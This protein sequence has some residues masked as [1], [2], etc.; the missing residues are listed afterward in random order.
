LASFVIIVK[1]LIFTF[2]L[3]GAGERHG[4]S[5]EVGIRLGQVSE[6]SLLISVLA[7]ESGF[8]GEITSNLIQMTTLL[9]FIVSSYLIVKY[10]PTPIAV[11][12][13]LRRD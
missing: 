6:F 9:T 13:N 10:Y 7:L 4:I 3:K 1:P 5:K 11:T 2:L 8:I 12:D